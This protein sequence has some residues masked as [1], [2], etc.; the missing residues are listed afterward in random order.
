MCQHAWDKECTDS[1]KTLFLGVSMKLVLKEI[2]NLI[3]DWVKILLIK[4]VSII[5]IVENPNR[6]K[7]WSKDEFTLCLS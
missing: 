5:Q 1:W 4:V 7:A 6:T 2:N 3:V